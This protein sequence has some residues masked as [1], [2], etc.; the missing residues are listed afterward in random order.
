MR[1]TVTVIINQGQPFLKTL[2]EWYEILVPIATLI[3][4]IIIGI[5]LF[6][7]NRQL[8]VSEKASKESQKA[9]NDSRKATEV[10]IVLRLK[11]SLIFNPDF[12]PILDALFNKK[13]ILIGNGGKVSDSI[14]FHYLNTLNE[15]SMFIH[16]KTLSKEMALQVFGG[17]ISSSFDYKEIKECINSIRKEQKDEFWSGID[18]I[19]K[20]FRNRHPKPV[21]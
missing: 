8:K 9:Y 19:A 15:I 11:E 12:K 2:A 13:P 5:T 16:N 20:E 18:E 14:L 10:D 7:V 3:T 17:L 1:I 6:F 21:K 4:A